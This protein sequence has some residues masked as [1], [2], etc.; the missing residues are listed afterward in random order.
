MAAPGEPAASPV[1]RFVT[2][3]C[4]TC[5]GKET[6]EAKLRLDTLNE[7]LTNPKNFAKWVTIYDRV[8]KGEMPPKEADQP[9]PTDRREFL[10][11]LGSRLKT[12]DL[13]R[14]KTQGR[15][16]LRRLNRVE[17]EYTLRDLLHLPYL[18]V[19]Q[20]LPPDDAAH[21]FDNVASAQDL[22]YVQISRYLEAAETALDRAICL[23]PKPER[24]KRKVVFQ[25]VGRFGRRDR[26][27]G[28]RGERGETRHVDEWVVFLRQPNSAQTPWRI[29]T[30]PG[31]SAAGYYKFRVRCRGVVFDHGKLLPQ[32]RRH[33]ASVYTQEKRLL[34]TIDIP[35][36]PGIVEF[37][38]WLYQGD[39]L[40]FFCA[41]L[42]DR[43]TPGAGP[44]KPYRGPGIAVEYLEVD[45]PI[46]KRWPRASHR[47][48]FGDLPVV[49]WTEA[50]GLR[51]PRMLK[52][53]KVREKR[54]RKRP[55]RR[56]GPA[57]MV[58]SKTPLKDAE[59]L[60]RRFMTRAYRRPVDDSELKRCLAFAKSA[61]AEKHCFQ[62][63]MHLAYKAALCSPDFLFFHEK[64]GRLDDYALA[65]RLSY[66]LW[67]SLPDDK[68]LA[69]AKAG[70]LGDPKVLRAQVE[71]MLA[72]EKSQ[73][74]VNDFTGQWLDLRK[75]HDTAPDRF[76]Y[77]EYFCDN[78]LV[79]SAVA[80]TRAYFAEM[81]KRNLGARFVV[82]S[83]FLMI[84][85][86]LAE[87]YGINGTRGRGGSENGRR[88]DGEKRESANTRISPSPPL[89][90]SPS[91]NAVSG[92]QL[93]KVAISPDTP[94][95][96]FLT[97][98]AV[99]K[100]TAN[101][102]TTSPVLR[103]TWVLDRLLGQ[104]VPPP[105]PDA[106]AIDPDTRGATTIR[107][108]LNKHRQVKSCAVCHVKLDP[109]GFALENFD[110]IGKW[111]ERYRSTGKGQVLKRRVADRP[112]RYKSGPKVDA[113]GQ[114]AD[115]NRFRDVREFRKLLLKNE[116]QIAK[117]LTTRLLTFATGAGVGFADR[118]VVEALLKQTKSDKHGLRS[119]IH[120]IVQ[121]RTF[122][123]K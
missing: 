101:G 18:D 82:A 97:Q 73:R 111:R 67:R 85:E 60:L 118:E 110:V 113:S 78:Y 45:G 41:T 116:P 100:V 95:G 64:P 47:A 39:K 122:Q 10:K 68:L 43:N 105:P 6:Q 99:L 72:D 90:V 51:E 91:H 84:N 22:S 83:D 117:N 66:F 34:H 121:S 55:R 24:V 25:R 29:G 37:T 79:E 104:P 4:T 44:K 9:K 16:P 94:R 76:L 119:L 13:R 20:I 71:R 30:K 70:R 86:R 88:R 23:G 3:H 109:P 33:V 19:K 65:S 123:H 50:S 46:L 81:L 11:E 1:R 58:R 52:P 17:Y 98:A 87:L 63:A 14:Q 35:E 112:V 26:K 108:Q 92:S 77:P 36:N 106:G 80:E 42:D 31:I 48:L 89:R 49:E 15:T 2:K 21:G 102:L 62:D 96:G 103:G 12:A 5:H 115:G 75:I 8:S 7:S 56:K 53:P 107:Q 32:D 120:A 61:I 54:Q 93:R 38:A 114:L 57:W 74:F 28:K 69:L 59:R 40:E 27:T